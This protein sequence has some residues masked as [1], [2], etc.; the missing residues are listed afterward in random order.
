MDHEFEML[1]KTVYEEPQCIKYEKQRFFFLTGNNCNRNGQ[2]IVSN[3]PL[4][5]FYWD[6]LLQLNIIKKNH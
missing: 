1:S 5:T 6:I 2:D 4:T 3:K